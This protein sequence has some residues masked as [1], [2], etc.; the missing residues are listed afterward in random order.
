M[1]LSL[2]ADAARTLPLLRRN[3]KR[4]T[5]PTV[6]SPG[7]AGEAEGIDVI[8][9][10][11]CVYDQQARRSSTCIP[12]VVN[13]LRIGRGDTRAGDGAPAAAFG[14]HAV[15]LTLRTAPQQSRVTH[16]LS[17]LRSTVAGV[18][19][20]SHLLFFQHLLNYFSVNSRP[21]SAL[22]CDDAFRPSAAPRTAVALDPGRSSVVLLQI[23]RDTAAKSVLH[24]RIVLTA[25]V[26]L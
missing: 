25:F 15:Q 14:V 3:M 17:R 16:C 19:A 11:D 18:D 5:V 23:D 12:V 13:D 10:A 9:A 2:P 22:S 20:G 7:S 26:E 4:N 24:L 21:N 1:P 6:L 8:T